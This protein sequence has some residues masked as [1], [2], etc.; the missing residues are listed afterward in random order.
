M[1]ALIAHTKD[2][3]RFRLK[4][5]CRRRARTKIESAQNYMLAG[6]HECN[7]QRETHTLANTCMMTYSTTSSSASNA[8]IWVLPKKN[9]CL[10]SDENSRVQE[11]DVLLCVYKLIS[12]ANNPSNLPNL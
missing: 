10:V 9:T 4:G 1:L 11:S 6:H 7:Q 8:W 5:L 12:L 3:D 2:I